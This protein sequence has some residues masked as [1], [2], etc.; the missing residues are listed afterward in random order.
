M[1]ALYWAVIPASIAEQFNNPIP[2]WP[3]ADGAFFILCPQAWEQRCPV[4]K[5][6]DSPLA[7]YAA[8]L[9]VLTHDTLSAL[10][11]R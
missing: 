5:V 7:V 3:A 2:G 11:Q 1:M 8:S 4:V 9:G 6:L 10:C